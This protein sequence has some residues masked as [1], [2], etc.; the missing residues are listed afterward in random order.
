MTARRIGQAGREVE[1]R[2]V[3]SSDAVA[4]DAA[5]GPCAAWPARRD[6]GSHASRRVESL[7]RTH[8]GEKPFMSGMRRPAARR[9][10]TSRRT[11][12]VAGPHHA[13]ARRR[14]RSTAVRLADKPEGY[15][16][17]NDRSAGT[18]GFRA[19]NQARDDGQTRASRTELDGQLLPENPARSTVR[20]RSCGSVAGN[21]P[22][23]RR[24]H[25]IESRFGRTEIQRGLLAG[26]SLIRHL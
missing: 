19:G 1:I 22:I 2:G 6:A 18:H 21:S 15:A 3:V 9:Q 11:A 10:S 16:A 23:E 17:A 4:A 8:R 20:A 26:R 24:R 13:H 25:M 5:A 12:D 14:S 7:Q